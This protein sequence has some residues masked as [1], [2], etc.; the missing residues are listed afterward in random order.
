MI[1]YAE[2]IMGN[3]IALAVLRFLWVSSEG[4]T[5]RKVANEIGFSPQAVHQA[6]QLLENSLLVT[7][8]RVGRAKFYEINREH[9]FVT[10]GLYPMWH[11]LDS[12]LELVGQFYL[13]RLSV[14]PLAILAFGSYTNGSADEK[15]DLDLLFIF[16]DEEM[17]PTMSDEIL[18]LDSSAYMRFGVHPSCKILTISGFKEEVKSGE[19]L[20]RTIYREGKSIAG[21]TPSEVISYD[22]KKNKDI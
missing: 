6:L 18:S 5:G 20:M 9:F 17:S 22:S 15:S 1:D 8:R 19:G 21:L 16:E 14:I 10:E 12:W 7:F 4:A 11:V 3:R 13:K 2:N